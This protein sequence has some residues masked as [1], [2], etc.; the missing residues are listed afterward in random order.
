MTKA[1]LIERI[2][3][4]LND[5]SSECPCDFLYM[6]PIT[7]DEA[8]MYLEEERAME[9]DNDFTPDECLPEEVTPELYMEAENCF[10]RYM[11]FE[12]RVERLAEFLTDNNCVCEYATYYDGDDYIDFFPV[13]WLKDSDNIVRFLSNASPLEVMQ[14][15]I[16]SR[17][18]FNPNHEFC[19]YDADNKILHSTDNPFRDGIA[20]AEAFA[21]AILSDTEAS[22]YIINDI[23]S[24][25]DAR[26]VLGCTKEE[27]FHE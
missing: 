17:V 27:F 13:D 12:A 7:L 11:Q 8:K 4:T 6:T 10:I 9:R 15:G 25:E 26:E 16:N 14:I 1:E 19:W 5:M 24:D 2:V 22:D 20:N 3:D 21:R 23:M 18:T